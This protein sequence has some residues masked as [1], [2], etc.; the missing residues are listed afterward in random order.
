MPKTALIN[1]SQELNLFHFSLENLHEAVLWVSSSG[2]IIRVNDAACKM[3]GYSKEELAQMQ[4]SDINPSPVF[5]NFSTFWQR[6]KKEKK[7][8]FEGQHRHKIGFLYDVEITGNYISYE[9]QEYSCS[10]V[11]DI[12]KRK[13]EEQLLRTISENTSGVTGEDYFKELTR[14]ITAALNV[15]YS[16]VVSCSNNETTKLR[17]LSYVDRQDILEN[18]E[19]D[20]KGT[21]CEIVMQGKDFFCPD[22]LDETFPREKGI[23]SWVAVP[24]YSPSTGKVIGNIAAFDNIPMTNEQNQSVILKIFAA[25]AGS[26]IERLNAEEKLMETLKSANIQLQQQLKESEERFATYLKKRPLRM[27]TRD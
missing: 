20:T 10:I 3:C 26:E 13:L 19:Y 5:T 17:M 12:R 2:Q 16:M 7:I 8:V 18:I 27:L 11:R 25:R 1:T 22:R 6:I 15:R 24:I 21:P 14:Y 23:K 9:G 4:V